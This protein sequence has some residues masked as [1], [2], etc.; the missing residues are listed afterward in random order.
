MD[1]IIQEYIPGCEF[2][3]FYYRRPDEQH[4]RIFSIT[5]KRFPEVIGDGAR[6]LERLILDDERAVCMALFYMAMNDGQTSRPS[7]WVTVKV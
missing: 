4:G 6:N 2:G 5:E 3:V 7:R 1:T